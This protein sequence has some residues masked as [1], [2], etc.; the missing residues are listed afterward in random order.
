LNTAE[1]QHQEP[2]DDDS[3]SLKIPVV[4]LAAAIWQRRRWLAAVTVLGML[5]AIGIGFLLPNQY[6]SIAQIMPPDQQAVSGTS[7]LSALAGGGG[8]LSGGSLLSEKTSGQISI[9]I[10]GSHTAQDDI[11]NRFDLMRVYGCRSRDAARNILTQQTFIEEDKKTGIVRIAVTGPDRYRARD[12][13]EAYVEELDKLL[14]AENTSSAHLERI[15]LEQRL[16]TLK[17][18][19][20]IA[21]NKLSQFS[22]RNATLNPQ[23]QGTSLLDAATRLQS[24]L[25]TAQGELSGLRAQ[26]S[27]DNVRVRS[28]QARID[29]LQ[30]QLRKMGGVGEKVD[31]TELKGDQWF[32]SIRELPILGA[33]YS[34]LY[35]Q[36]ITQEGIYDTLSKQYE[37]AKVQEA[38]EIPTIKVLDHP[39]VPERKIGP[40]RSTFGIVGALLAGCAGFLWIV[41]RTLWEIAGDRNPLKRF[42]LSVQDLIRVEDLA[43]RNSIGSDG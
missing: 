37:L 23:S 38:K 29:E 35:R 18:N 41:G 39:E 30:S 15:F 36:L 22:S 43:K 42:K 12:I 13:A 8:M 33:A 27:T 11:I 14:N 21:A 10:L 40:H 6:T 19:L 24:E 16:T 32:P 1:E 28:V 17:T 4:E 25:N 31:G 20:D 3:G 7:M 34:D 5:A 2:A 9:S 26:Y